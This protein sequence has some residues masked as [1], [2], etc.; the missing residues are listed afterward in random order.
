MEPSGL[1]FHHFLHAAARKITIKGIASCAVS[2][3]TTYGRLLA[4]FIPEAKG[5]PAS[6]GECLLHLFAVCAVMAYCIALGP[7][8]GVGMHAVV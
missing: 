1:L 3:T 7:G 2:P 4:A 8:A 6:V 5:S